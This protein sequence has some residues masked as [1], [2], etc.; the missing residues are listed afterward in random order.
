MRCANVLSGK[1]SPPRIHDAKIWLNPKGCTTENVTMSQW[2]ALAK[3]QAAEQAGTHDGRKHPRFVAHNIR[4]SKGQVTDFSA[5]GLRITYGK[6]MRFEI[7]AMLD[8]EL[9]TPSGVLRCSAEV[10]WTQ[11]RSRKEFVAGFRFEDPEV[12]KTLRLFDRGFDPLSI[13]VLDC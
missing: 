13:G 1:T 3:L 4:C 2:T 6:D 8:L 12:H 10:M 7:G 11:R 9:C 5:T